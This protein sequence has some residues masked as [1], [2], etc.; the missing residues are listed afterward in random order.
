MANVVRLLAGLFFILAGAAYY[1]GVTMASFA[2]LVFVVAGALVLLLALL[3]HRATG[4]DIALFVCGLLILAFVISPAFTSPT[5]PA[6]SRTLAKDAISAN[7]IAIFASTDV[8]SIDVSISDRPGLG[9]QVNFTQVRAPFF[10]FPGTGPST[11]LTNRTEGSTL[12][13]NASARSYDISITIGTGYTLDVTATAGTGSVSIRSLASETLGAVSLESGTGSVTGDLT[14][15]TVGS[16]KLQAGTGSLRLSS[17]H[18]APN[19]P[20]VPITLTTGTGSLDLSV[21]FADGTAVSVDATTGMGS[22]NNNL[23]GF[24]VSPSSTNTR[25]ICQAGDL[26]SAPRSF[27]V[28]ASA[29]TGSINLS[30]Q[31]G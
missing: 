25:L 9:Y 17:D 19:G 23:Q 21:R 10:L 18:L 20:R 8:G 28:S 6:I 7:Q 30:S 5:G 1:F 12:A 4:G 2:S 24:N 14:S 22:I 27:E 31:F 3:G 15:K 11:T 26:A 13:L 16:I 29:G